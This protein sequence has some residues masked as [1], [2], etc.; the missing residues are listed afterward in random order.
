MGEVYK[1]M[2]ARLGRIVAIKVLPAAMTGDPQRRERFDREARLVSSLNHPHICALYHVGRHDGLD[3]LVMEY[4]DGETLADRLTRAQIPGKETLSIARQIAEALEA[5]HD[6]GIVH[7][8]LKPSNVMITADGHV[9]VLDFGL[10]THADAGT[11]PDVS[12]SPTLMVTGAGVIL[13]TAVYMSPEQA[14]GKEADRSSDVWA[15]GC[16]FFEMLTDHRAFDG[17]TVSEIIANVLKSEPAWHRLPAAT[18]SGVSRLLHLSLQKDRRLR[19]RDIRDWRLE[20]T[21][22]HSAMPFHQPRWP[23]RDDVN[24]SPGRRRWWSSH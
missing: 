16:V 23:R 11:R 20:L 4:L 18:P 19:L 24:A 5:A 2:D 6:K 10:A 9:K 14:N 8:D 17:N 12:N 3:F 13:G 7:R 22:G 1:A 21:D 15:F